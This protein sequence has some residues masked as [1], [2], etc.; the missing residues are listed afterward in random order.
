MSEKPEQHRPGKTDS[1]AA[2]IGFALLSAASFAAMA[3]CVR[4]ASD[5]LPQS[6]LVF[7]RNFVAMLFLLPL[8]LRSHTSLRTSYFHLHLLRAA[9]GLAAMY[10]YFYA[11]DQLR[12]SDALLLNYT[13]PLFIAIF[14]VLWLKERWSMQARIAL[15]LSLIGIILLFRPGGEL[16]SAAGLFGLIS[17]ALAGLALTTVKRLSVSETPVNIV[18]WFALIASALSAIPMMWSFILP[19]GEQWWWLLAMGLFGSL[20]QL[21][22]TWAY[23]RAP[24]T[25]VAPLGYSSL[26]FAGLIGF[27]AWQEV[28]DLIGIGGM[29]FI[30]AAGIVVA[31]ERDT[32]APQPP[33]GVPVIESI[34][35]DTAPPRQA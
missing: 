17:G 6:E 28:P 4:V 11:I 24:I 3:A 26:L 31:R 25:R 29:I 20:G 35:N 27:F 5:A 30:V 22:L 32:P 33:S 2:W 18:V 7:F 8:L 19:Q 14:A 1:S 9:S 13:S 16:F 10:F 21:G 12:L 34:G 15:V 23:R